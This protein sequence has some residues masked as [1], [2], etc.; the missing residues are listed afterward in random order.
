MST[1][2]VEQAVPG[3]DSGAPRIAGFEQRR[4]I[5]DRVFRGTL[6]A[7]S[8]LT[9]FCVFAYLTGM[10]TAIAGSPK[11]DA[12]SLAGVLVGI[13]I[14]NV[15]WA[16]VWY[17]VKSSLLKRVVG[18]SAEER[19]QAFSSRMSRPFDLPG[20][21][22]HHSERRI[23]IVDMIGRRGRFVTIALAGFFYLY[24]HI[25]SGRPENFAAAFLGANLLD[26]VLTSWLFLAFFYSSNRFAT[27]LYGAQTRIMDGVLARAN[28]LL[29]ATLW[30]LFK[31]VLV[32]VGTQ[33]AA[34]YPPEQFALVFAL[35]WGSYIVTDALAEIGGALYGRQTIRVIGIGDVNRKSVG[36][37]LTGFAGSLVFCTGLV[38]A[39]G[40]PPSWLLL[41]MV[42]SL[43]NTLL[44]LFSPRGTDDFTMTTSN[45]LICWAFGALIIA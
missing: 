27:V 40:L 16:F 45:A 15:V 32:P 4:R 14:F 11:L 7:N 20:L 6:L 38:L 10:G 36:G 25:A 33:L 1:L 18:F 19:H 43:S 12:A 21:L 42:I 41:A 28:F 5:A 2:S 17:V 23:R 37:T 13:L 39:N 3:M 31:F 26:A 22:A 34:I 35:I 8:A 29:I 24:L 9:L 44:E 30:T